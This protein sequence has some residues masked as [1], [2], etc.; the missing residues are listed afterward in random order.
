MH[1]VILDARDK[2]SQSVDSREEQKWAD[3]R[4]TQRTW[5]PRLEVD[6]APIPWDASICKFQRGRAGY[7]AEALEQPLLLPKDMDAYRRF[8]QN[9]LFL[10][11][12]RDLAMVN[13]LSICE[14]RC[15][16]IFLFSIPII[17]WS[18]GRL[19]NK[20][21]WS[22]SGIVT[23][24]SRPMLRPSLVPMLRNRWGWLSRSKLSCS[25]N[26]KW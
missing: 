12:K 7:I 1:K 13:N 14:F 3:M 24:I 8:T 5:S 10:S 25:R 11:L 4:M 18:L 6:G 23:L 16:I 21:L 19:L 15:Q 9:D 22:R 17:F 2:R 20:S 26:S